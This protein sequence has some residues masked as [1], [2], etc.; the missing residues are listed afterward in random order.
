MNQFVYNVCIEGE[1][2]IATNMLLGD[3]MILVE[4]LFS[5][6]FNEPNLKIR[7]ERD[8]IALGSCCENK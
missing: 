8:D 5:K 3:A 7:I 1:R 6:Y 2:T 4:A